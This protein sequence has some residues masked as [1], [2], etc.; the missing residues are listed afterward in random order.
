MDPDLRE[1]Q[2]TM[3]LSA[4]GNRSS[5]QLPSTSNRLVTKNTSTQPLFDVDE[6][7]EGFI[8]E[9][10]GLDSG[11]DDMLAIAIQASLDQ[12]TEHVPHINTTPPRP[13]LRQQPSPYEPLDIAKYAF[14]T[15][16]RLETALSIA[17]AGSSRNHRLPV[18][19]SVSSVFG[20]PTLLSSS[21]SEDTPTTETGSPV[22]VFERIIGS[23]PRTLHKSPK[24]TLLHT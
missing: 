22:E 1:Y 2:Q 19:S 9:S 12:E 24:R 17:N 20:R 7:D 4:I 18:L 15:P 8:Q 21:V 3:A 10:Y 11:D 14:E 23:L 13:L 6:E 5:Q 16:T